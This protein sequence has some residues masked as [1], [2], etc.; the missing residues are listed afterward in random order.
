MK[1][2]ATEW[3][4]FSTK[5]LPPEV[6][7]LQYTEMRKAFYA[8]AGALFHS[9]LKIL[10]PGQEATE[11]DLLIMDGIQAELNEFLETLRRERAAR[12][13]PAP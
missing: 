10:G 2:I 12:A 5:V 1:V 13:G 3:E 11:S 7:R 8:G 4:S 9:I 6:S